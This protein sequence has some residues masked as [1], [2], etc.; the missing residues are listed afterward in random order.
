ML[1]FALFIRKYLEILVLPECSIF[2]VVIFG[3][4]QGQNDQEESHMC[5]IGN[6]FTLPLT[7]F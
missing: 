7:P 3:H 5:S 6:W 1:Y 2:L 4:E